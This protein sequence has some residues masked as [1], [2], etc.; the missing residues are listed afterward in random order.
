[1]SATFEVDHAYLRQTVAAPLTEA[2]AR[3]AAAQPEDP[4]EFLGNYLLKHVANEVAKQQQQQDAGRPSGGALSITELSAP[5]MDKELAH[6]LAQESSLAVQLQSET[7]VAKLLQRYVE[8]LSTALGAEEA[9]IGRKEVDAAGVPVVHF[10]TSSRRPSSVTVDKTVTE[11]KGITFD[12]F[13]E[14][15]ADPAA[16]DAD[17]NPLPPSLPK[18]IHIENVLREPRMKFF[19][20][21]KLGAYLTRAVQYKSYLHP[22]VFNDGNPEETNALEQWMVVSVDSMGQARAFTEVEIESFQ[23]T[24][25]LF[26]STL[27]NLERELYTKDRERQTST[28]EAVLHDFRTAYASQLTEREENLTV[29]L[30]GITDEHEKQLREAEQRLVYLTELLVSFI[31]TLSIVSERTIPLKTSALAVFA[32]ALELLGH[33]RSTLLNPVTKTP[34]WDRISQLLEEQSLQSDFARFQITNPAVTGSIKQ[35]IEE[36]SKEDVE[37]VSTI[38]GCFYQWA[39]ASIALRE[40]LDAAEERARQRQLEEQPATNVEGADDS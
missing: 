33:A 15:E 1:M 11:E 38:A 24:T 14:I 37:K 16:T 40:Q 13:K 22:E 3:L 21:P 9:Y 4:I 5:A 6:F 8:W 18:F 35:A 23:R 2:M 36:T 20:V 27:E 39:K 28:E 7:N 17:G 26:T 10:V 29:Q 34:A 32:V 30:Q 25:A 19:G 31:P 12:A